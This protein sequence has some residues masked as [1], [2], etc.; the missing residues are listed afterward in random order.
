VA[1]KLVAALV[2]GCVLWP[3]A[4]DAQARV[5]VQRFG[6]P[7]GARLRAA[8]I[9][10]LEENGIEVV[11]NR[12]VQR[13]AREA[14]GRS[15]LRSDDFPTVAAQLGVSAFLSGRV[16]RRGRRFTLTVSVRNAADGSRL[17]SA[18]WGGRN[19]GS[20]RAIGRNGYARLEQYLNVAQVPAGGGYAQQQQPQQQQ[21]QQTFQAGGTGGT[22]WYAA[23]QEPEETP[24]DD[25]EDEDEEDEEDDGEVAPYDKLHLALYVGALRRSMSTTVF[26]SEHLRTPGGSTDNVVPE[27]REYQ[28]AGLGHAEI[29][30]TADLFPGALADD[31][32]APW[33]GLALSFRNSLLLQSN[34]FA[35]TNASEPAGGRAC[36]DVLQVVPIRTTQRE[37][38]VG[39][40]VDYRFDSSSRQ[41]AYLGVDL[42]YGLFSFRL[43][44]E[45]LALIER[46]QIIPPM[47]YSYIHIGGAFRYQADEEGLFAIGLRAAYRL[48]L[49]VGT[50]AKRIWGATTSSM[51]GLMVGV[52]L[53]H[54]MT[55][56]TE[57]VFAQL[58]L[59]WFRFTTT[60]T[61]Q[62][63][64][65]VPPTDGGVCPELDL[66][67]PWP[68]DDGTTVRP[69]TGVPDPV[70]D[71][72]LRLGVSIGYALR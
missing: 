65:R 45:D 52:D 70:N 13:V 24:P 20:L 72:Y 60:F 64:C 50:D 41:S 6:G 8:L 66:W 3:S 42:G 43:A 59:D 51:S 25:E 32:V 26:V 33:L 63:T 61:G 23:G 22:P 14:V 67:E 30:F 16:R 47:D 54:E 62:P 69:G 35:C 11:D 31:P 28:S 68:S 58:S 1:A 56:L 2:L 39:A 21:Q 17:G 55:Y 37:I 46:N 71:S 29:G 44:P 48:G 9:N 4:V 38:Y 57:G 34:G 49:D 53:R 27:L 36:S 7:Q 15:N 40:K 5:V 12:E 18:S 10:D 19:V